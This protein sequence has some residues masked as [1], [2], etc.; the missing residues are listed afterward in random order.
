MITRKIV[1]FLF[2]ISL[3]FIP[4]PTVFS[5]AKVVKSETMLFH[6]TNVEKKDV[7]FSF[8]LTPHTPHQLFSSEWFMTAKS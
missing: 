4:R 8:D 3:F 7:H 6:V 2:L 1:D 5:M